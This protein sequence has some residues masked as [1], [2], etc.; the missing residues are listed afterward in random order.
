MEKVA[1]IILAAG[2]GKR[3]HSGLAK[4]LH[5]L[6]GKPMLGYPLEVTLEN[7]HPEK[8]LVVIGHQGEE[9]LAFFSDPR[10]TFVEQEEQLGTG[11]A[12]S[13]VEPILGKFKGT[14]LILCGDIPLIQAQTLRAMLNHH[15]EKD[16]T[17]TLLTATM[18]DPT[19]YGRVVRGVLGGVRKVIEEKDSKDPE[20][21][22]KEIN[23]GIYCVQSPFLFHALKQLKSDNFQGEYY[24][25][26]IIEIA[27]HEKQK[28]CTHS[29]A[30]PWEI[31]GLN[32]RAH[33]AKAEE[34]LHERVRQRWMSDDVTIQDPKSVYIETDVRIGRDTIIYPNC[35]L[36]GKTSIGEGC[37]IGPQVEIRDSQIGDRVRIRF[38]TLITESTIEDDSTVGPF[39]HLRPLTHLEKG[40]SIGNFVEVKKSRIRKGTKANHLSYIGDSDV[41]EAVNI[42]AGTIT[43]NYDGYQKHQTIIED[44]VFVGSNTALVAPVK[45]GK[46]ALVGAGATITKDVAPFALAVSR[47]KQKN[48]KKWVIKRDKKRAKE[49]QRD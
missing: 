25:T 38:C 12:V 11:H 19:G 26:D 17:I 9:I 37:Q 34:I 36:C 27:H 49:N 40:V 6:L 41:G 23:S 28:I 4:V 20:R 29:P 31:F 15:W 24:L 14:L 48:I 1:V 33:L 5:P 3:M 22:I 18:E 43:C 2:Q 7:L 39:T 35:Y 13:V 44:G 21:E 32:T 42:G 8:T 10:I 45:I 46:R 47:P 30:D 16:A